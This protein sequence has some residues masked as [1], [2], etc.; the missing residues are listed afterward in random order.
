MVSGLE[1]GLTG[2]EGD[3]YNSQINIKEGLSFLGIEGGVWGAV[4]CPA[5]VWNMNIQ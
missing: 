3:I 4:G 2:G 5:L 1:E